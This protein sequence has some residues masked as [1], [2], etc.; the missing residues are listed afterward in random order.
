M[1]SIDPARRSEY[2]NGLRQLAD[3]LD[4]N[5]DMPV[6]GSGT[7]IILTAADAEDGGITEV[8]GLSLLLGAPLTE[9]NGFYRTSRMF[10]PLTYLGVSQ[11]RAFL[12][13]YRAYNSYYGSVTPDD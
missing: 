7:E 3:Y 11:T 13:Q 10:G 1:F 5:P 4:A 6:P 2:T 8:L 12:A 9:R